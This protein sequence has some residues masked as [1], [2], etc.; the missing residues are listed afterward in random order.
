MSK[1]KVHFT[2]TQSKYFIIEADTK[3]E[4]EEKAEDMLSGDE[5]MGLV[6]EGKHYEYVVDEAEEANGYTRTP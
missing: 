6:Y 3:S 2:E 1:Y 4:A 5:V